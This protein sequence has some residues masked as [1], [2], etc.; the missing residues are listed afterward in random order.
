[1]GLYR[2]VIYRIVA[3]RVRMKRNILQVIPIFIEIFKLLLI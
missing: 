2:D 1:M 3:Q